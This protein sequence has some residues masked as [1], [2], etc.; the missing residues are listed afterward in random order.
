MSRMQARPTGVERLFADD[1]VIVSKTDTKGRIT[2]V[3]AVMIRVCGYSR[4]ELIRA[5]HSIIRHPAMP[6]CVFRLLWETIEAGSEVFAYVVNLA[7]NGDHYW[8]LAHVTPTFDPAGR[9][10][11][12]HS[13]RRTVD[14]A[15]LPI[16]TDLYASLLEIERTAGRRDAVEASMEAFTSI[17][18][19]RGQS[20]DEFVWSLA[21][22][23]VGR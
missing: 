16:V 6:R 15:V 7:K 8:V 22:A 17:L 10:V 14:R 19:E 12:H 9:I 2:Y 21:A 5:P 13:N 18:A 23:P 3:N 20:Y 4:E 1:E 11:G